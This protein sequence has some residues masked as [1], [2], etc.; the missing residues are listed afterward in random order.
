MERR[1]REC[2]IRTVEQMCRAT[3]D[4][5]RHAWNGVQGARVWRL[6]RGEEVP[7]PPVRKRVIGHSHVLSPQLRSDAGARAVCH[8]LLQKAAMRLRKSGYCA[9]GLE[10]SVRGQQ[11]KWSDDITF[12]ETQDT[13]EF[14]RALD[15]LWSRRDA[16]D[17]PKKVAVTLFHLQ[18]QQASTPMFAALRRDHSALCVAMDKVNLGFGSNKVYFGGAHHALDHA[19]MRIAFTRIPDPETEG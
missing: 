8:R 15:T 14:L 6:L 18:V 2:G 9:G 5:L 13:L 19:P 3:E 17:A 7:R 1:L 12:S 11:D 16:S 10:L 4:E